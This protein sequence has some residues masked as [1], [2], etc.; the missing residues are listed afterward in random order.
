MRVVYVTQIAG[1]VDYAAMYERQ[2]QVCEAVASGSRSPTL[3]LLEH[4]PTITLGRRARRE[5]IVADADALARAG[6][7][8]VETDRGGDVTYHGPGQLVV[9]PIL[10]LNTWRPSVNWYIRA[11]EE[12]VIRLLQSFGLAGERRPG[13]TGVWVDE[14]KVAAVGVGLRHWTTYHGLAVNVCPDEEHWQM[15]IPCGI[16]YRP[17]TSLARLL[18]AQPSMD[19]V[20]ARYLQAFSKTFDCRLDIHRE[21]WPA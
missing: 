1:L 18:S 2:L 15:I 11:L 21:T 19:E 20:V 6:V 4:T 5:H 3:F 14:G 7:R 17:V 13:L 12:T 16:P 8:C 10:D 9:Y